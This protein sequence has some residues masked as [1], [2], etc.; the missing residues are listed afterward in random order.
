[1]NVYLRPQTL[2]NPQAYSI[3]AALTAVRNFVVTT[4]E[5][6]LTKYFTYVTVSWLGTMNVHLRPQTLTNPESY[7][8]SVVFTAIGSFIV[9]TLENHLTKY[10]NY[11]TSKLG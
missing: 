7:S 10:F 8:I 2:T 11:V 1:M 3:S 5:N 4:L 6:H 9:T